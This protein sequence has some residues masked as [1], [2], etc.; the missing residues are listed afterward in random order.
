MLF[1]KGLDGCEGDFAHQLAVGM[2]DGDRNKIGV[3]FVFEYTKLLTG[4]RSYL[5]CSIF[6]NMAMSEPKS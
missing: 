4:L 2:P 1:L 5:R 6:K 3:R